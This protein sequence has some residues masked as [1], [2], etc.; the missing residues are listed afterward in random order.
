MSWFSSPPWDEVVYWALDLETGGL[1]PRT[2]AILAVGL[3]PVRAGHVRLREAY[4]TL[5]R[6]EPGKTIHPRSVEAHQ[7][8]SGDTRDAPALAAVLPEIDARIRAGVLL[9]HHAAL[10]VKFL[11]RAYRTHG[12]RWPAPAVVDTVALLLAAARRAHRRTPELPADPPPLN[13]SAARDRFGLPRYEAHDP[14]V[15]A[16]AT[17]ELFLVL[18]SALGARTLRDLR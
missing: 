3:V 7:L 17:A 2:D 16:V 11:E 9:V 6:P 18:R 13:L 14:L 15:D 4:R 5:V 1:D 8:V 10:D 12:L